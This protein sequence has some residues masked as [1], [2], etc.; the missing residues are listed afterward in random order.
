M[1]EKRM[2]LSVSK[3]CLAVVLLLSRMGL[4]PPLMETAVLS[5]VTTLVRWRVPSALVMTMAMD[6]LMASALISLVTWRLGAVTE[7]EAVPRTS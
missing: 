3:R 4:L 6:S 5:A 2:E 1:P 7:E